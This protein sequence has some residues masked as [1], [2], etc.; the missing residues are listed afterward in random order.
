M[1]MMFIIEDGDNDYQDGRRMTIIIRVERENC[2]DN[3]RN[4]E[5]IEVK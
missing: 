4:T 5:M 1:T 3:G 2:E